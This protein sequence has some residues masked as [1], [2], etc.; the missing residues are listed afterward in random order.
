[1]IL[2]FKEKKKVLKGEQEKVQ[3]NLQ[4]CGSG[5]VESGSG[6]GSRTSTLAEI[7]IYLFLV[8][9]PDPGAPLNPDPVRI[10]IHSTEN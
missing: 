5:L 6:Y 4:C 9:D 2:L 7:F 3:I 1:M 10:R 8:P